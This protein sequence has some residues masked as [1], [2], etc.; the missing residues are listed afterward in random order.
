VPN[1]LVDIR[2]LVD[3]QSQTDQ[4]FQSVR[5]YTRLSAAAVRR[6]LIQQQGYRDEEL[7][8][9]ESIRVK[10]KQ[11]EYKL[12]AVQKSHPQKNS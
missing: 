7:P 10:L 3:G 2:A 9:V 8:P 11:L 6:Q 12:R 5:L 1:L 4:T